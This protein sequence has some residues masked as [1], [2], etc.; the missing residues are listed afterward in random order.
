MIKDKSKAIIKKK[1]KFQPEYI[2]GFNSVEWVRE[3]RDNT[4]NKHKGKNMKEYVQSILKKKN[5]K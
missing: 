3:V 2:E 5:N 4:Y 1:I